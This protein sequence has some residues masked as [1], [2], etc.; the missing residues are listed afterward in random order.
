MVCTLSKW[1]WKHKKELAIAGISIA[2]LIATILCIKNKA[3]VLAYW[4]ALKKAI[5]QLR[6]TTDAPVAKVPR[7]KIVHTTV[8]A[9][10]PI[11]QQVTPSVEDV[12]RVAHRACTDPCV[13]DPHIRNLPLGW[14]ASAEKIATAQEKGFE[15]Q[16]GQTWIDTYVADF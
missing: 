16:D 12:P 7:Q 6:S 10:K 11:N 13:V 8:K 4:A 14:H 2:A 1:I 3:T 9:T 5:A 15:L